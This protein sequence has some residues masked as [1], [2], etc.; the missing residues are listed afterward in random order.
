VYIG[1]SSALGETDYL[2]W[3]SFVSGQTSY[4][5][6]L[7]GFALDYSTVYYWKVVPTVDAQS[8][9]DAQ[10]VEVWSFTTELIPWPNNAE[11]PNPEDGGKLLIGA[12]HKV[13]LSW[14]FIPDPSYSLPAYFRLYAASDTNT[15]DWQNTVMEINYVSGQTN[16]AVELIDHP[17]F[18][19]T[20]WIDNYWKI[21]PVAHGEQGVAPDVPVWSFV[22]DDYDGVEETNG[23]NLTIFPNPANDYVLVVPTFTGSY[24]LVLYDLKGQLLQRKYV[25][26]GDVNLSLDGLAQGVYQL[27]IIYQGRYISRKIQKQ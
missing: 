25:N 16:Y 4:N 12:E 8:G 2:G 18:D 1:L 17:N 15:A 10:G 11:N 27:L 20:Y 23:L 14:D 6:S 21:V 24:E 3:V 19:Y 26:E 22:F 13:D 7:S 9:P 5:A